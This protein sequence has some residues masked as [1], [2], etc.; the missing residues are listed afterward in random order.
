M[1]FLY[2][3]TAL[4]WSALP[5]SYVDMCVHFTVE[6]QESCVLHHPIIPNFESVLE[7]LLNFIFFPFLDLPTELFPNN[8]SLFYHPILLQ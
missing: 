3:L 6:G 8:I 4:F 2:N 7:W 5:S 1:P